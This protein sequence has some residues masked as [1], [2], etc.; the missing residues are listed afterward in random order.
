V[1]TAINP[2]V[3]LSRIDNPKLEPIAQEVSIRLQRVI[4]AV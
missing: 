3:A 2:I 1:V 4:A